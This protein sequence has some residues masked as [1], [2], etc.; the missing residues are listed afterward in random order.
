[1]SIRLVTLACFALTVSACQPAATE[2]TPAAAAGAA[3]SPKAAL[4]PGS[5]ASTPDPL[6]T[7][8]KAVEASMDK[9]LAARSFHASMEMQAAQPMKVEM[10]FVAPD[11]YRMRMPEATQVVIGDTMYMQAGGQTMKMPLPAGT[12]GKWRDPL[13]MQEGKDAMVVTALGS[14]RVDG[15]PARKFQVRHGAPDNSEVTYWIGGD[16]LPLKLV[17]A[18]DSESGPYTMTIL[19]SR[20]DDP[21]IS[22]E[23]PG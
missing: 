17:H 14:E 18:G 8:R 11:R 16:D 10:D 12:L 1:M 9:F 2:P 5:A 3:G 13:K 15:E 22:I 6:S 7:P 20:F 23:P 21:S 4:A 19:Y